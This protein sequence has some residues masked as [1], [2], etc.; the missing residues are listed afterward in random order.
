VPLWGLLPLNFQN[1]IN[2]IASAWMAGTAA[3]L[4]KKVAEKFYIMKVFK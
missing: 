2:N 3:L 4:A 1:N